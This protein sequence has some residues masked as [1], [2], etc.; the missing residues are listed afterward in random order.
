MAIHFAS[1]HCD[2]TALMPRIFN[3]LASLQT[4]EQYIVHK[5]EQ[6]V[7]VSLAAL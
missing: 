7:I 6:H 5:L 4:N 3:N 2:P 1:D